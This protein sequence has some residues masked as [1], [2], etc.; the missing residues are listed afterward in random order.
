LNYNYIQPQNSLRSVSTATW[1]SGLLAVVLGVAMMAWPRPTVDTAA[2]LFGVYLVVS[3]VALTFLGFVLPVAA[4]TRFLSLISGVASITLGILA[5][6]DFGEERAI[7]LLAIWVGAGF[8]IRGVF[9]TGSAVGVPQ[10]PGRW[11]ANFL[12]F[13][14]IIVG[15][16][17]LAF[18][19]ESIE[20]LT[21]MTGAWLTIVGYLE[22]ISGFVMRG[23]ATTTAGTMGAMRPLMGQGYPVAPITGATATTGKSIALQ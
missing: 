12:G 1:L 17:V 21:L 15:F 2:V 22:V 11:W 8:I 18:P 16:V 7:L 13:I 4:A 5:F 20:T 19:F 14:S 23:D 6:R 10:F 3:G 9:V